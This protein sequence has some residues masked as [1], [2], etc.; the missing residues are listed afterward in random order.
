M[1]KGVRKQGFLS[2]ATGFPGFRVLDARE[3]LTKS[4]NSLPHGD[5]C[6]AHL[7]V[8]NK[9][10]ETVNVPDKVK[11]LLGFV[12]SY[13]GTA[14]VMCY[15]ATSA[16]RRYTRGQP[17]EA[18][19]INQVISSA[20]DFAVA[21]RI[22]S[23]NPCKNV[24]LPKLEHKEMQT[25]PAEQLQA[26]LEEAKRSGVYEM[27]CIELSTG[28]RRGE[29]LGLKWSD[30]DWKNSIIKIRRQVARI[31]GKIVEA[32][33]KTKNSYRAVSISPQAAEVL[34]TQKAKTND[35]Y[36]FPSPNGDPVSPDSVNNMLKRVLERAGIPKVR[37]HDLRHP[38]PAKRRGHQNRL[39]H[40]RPLLRRLHPGHL[41]PCDNCSPKRSR[42][43]H[44]ECTEYR[45]PSIIGERCQH[46]KDAGTSINAIQ[47]YC[48]PA[49]GW[50]GSMI[51][52]LR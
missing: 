20:M 46:R 13:F 51:F 29:L 48:L 27:Y 32:P 24:S 2:A 7:V 47:Q 14:V 50:S 9:R 37:F 31:D 36:V 4:R 52:C 40:A 33:L 23:E 42:P 39:R 12:D 43:G 1:G 26:F 34:K 49:S 41:C 15:A 25:I 3:D 28:L 11:F 5:C 16:R 38:R 21:Q 35:E 30:I 10:N 8:D 45:N 19:S 44:G 17:S 6:L 18:R 22:I